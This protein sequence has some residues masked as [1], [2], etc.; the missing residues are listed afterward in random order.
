MATSVIPS[1]SSSSSAR[2]VSGEAFPQCLKLT[3]RAYDLSQALA[4]E[5]RFQALADVSE[6]EC[7]FVLRQILVQLFES[8]SRR[9]VNPRDRSRVHDKPAHGRGRFGRQFARLDGEA[10]NVCV[11]EIG[12]EPIHHQPRRRHASRFHS[13]RLPIALGRL[14]FHRYRRLVAVAYMLKQRQHEREQDAVFHAEKNYGSSGYEGKNPLARALAAQIVQTP[15]IHEMDGNGEDNRAKHADRKKLQW[16]GE[17]KEHEHDHKGRREV[18]HLAAATGGFYHR[19]LRRAA[20]DYKRSAQSCR[21][22]GRGNAKQIAILIQG[23]MMFCGVGSSGDRALSHDHH[24]ARAGYWQQFANKPPIQ[25]RDR[26]MRQSACDGTDHL[27]S[28]S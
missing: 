22:V 3:V 25:R 20:V 23:L 27:D 15:Q 17:E 8:A 21:R 11:E 5:I 14:R 13:A 10:I 9:V 12:P 2:R 16:T 4:I 24:E 26:K 19:S 6:D 7:D 1:S 18:R 28:V